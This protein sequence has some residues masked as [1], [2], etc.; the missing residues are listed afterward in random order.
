MDIEVDSPNP[1]PVL[2]SVDLRARAGVARIHAPRDSQVSSSAL[3]AIL[4][5][6]GWCFFNC[7]KFFNAFCPVDYLFVGWCEFLNKAALTFEK[8]W[9]YWSLSRYKGKNFCKSVVVFVSLSFQWLLCGQPC[10]DAMGIKMRITTSVV[11]TE[12]HRRLKR[13]LWLMLKP[14]AWI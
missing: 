8:C 1:I 14:S 12:S 3:Y 11:K 7:D 2:R 13:M 6:P 5:C 4:M 10:Q 9:E